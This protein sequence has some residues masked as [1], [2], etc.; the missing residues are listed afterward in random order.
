MLEDGGIALEKLLI[1]EKW[2]QAS[3]ALS[4]MIFSAAAGLDFSCSLCLSAGHRV[5]NFKG[6]P[7]LDSQFERSLDDQARQRR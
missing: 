7:Q 4:W 2:G 5:Q 3:G 6:K 1:A